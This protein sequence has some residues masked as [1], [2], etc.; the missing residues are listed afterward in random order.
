MSRL[1]YFICS[2]TGNPTHP[3]ALYL[4]TEAADVIADSIK[5]HL[6]LVR[7]LDMPLDKIPGAR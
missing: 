4:E 2:D 3:E 7:A 6:E 1:A 5:H